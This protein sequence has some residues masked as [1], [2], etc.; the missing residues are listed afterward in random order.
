MNRLERQRA[1]RFLLCVVLLFVARPAAAYLDPS[2]GSIFLQALVAGS[3]AALVTLK[4]YWQK[5]R[6]FIGRRF[7]RS[8]AEEPG[9]D[10]DAG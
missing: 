3:L 2:S 4:L 1:L 5:V 8:S 9:S 7:G 6:S 10:T